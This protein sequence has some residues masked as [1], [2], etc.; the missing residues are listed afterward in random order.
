MHT[1]LMVLAFSTHIDM[2][3]VYMYLL[4]DT[5]YP[6]KKCYINHDQ[7]LF[8]TFRYLLYVEHTF[9]RTLESNWSYKNRGY[10][11]VCR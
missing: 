2:N 4:L 5:L 6:K 9:I 3:Y 7:A 11:M 1:S 8:S 10:S